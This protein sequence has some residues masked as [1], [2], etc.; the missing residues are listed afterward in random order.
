VPS[1]HDLPLARLH[2]A[3]RE[4]DADYLLEALRLDP[5]GAA[6][7][8]TWLAD[9][10]RHDAIPTLVELLDVGSP[11]ARA[12]AASALY[13]LGP[14]L[15]AKSRL[16]EMAGSD[17]DPGARV[18]ALY[19]LSKFQDRALVPLLI[20]ALDSPDTQVRR[21]AVTALGETGDKEALDPVRRARR[22][23]RRTPLSWYMNHL[24]YR[25]ALAALEGPTIW[26]TAGRMVRWLVRAVLFAAAI[27]VV[28][29]AVYGGGVSGFLRLTAL[30]LVVLVLVR[31]FRFI[32]RWLR[33]RLLGVG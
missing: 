17:P 25:T 5:H 31:S 28:L 7:A 3:R 19:A 24:A 16:V 20:R 4:G 29:I 33:R 23:E 26:A 18:W 32:W 8:A 11:L 6:I 12:R 10:Q 21:A 9:M 2:Q 1:D 14:P 27:A 30:L 13:K 15:Q 22:R